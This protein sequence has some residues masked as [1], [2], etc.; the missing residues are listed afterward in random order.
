MRT[1]PGAALFRATAEVLRAALEAGA[2]A[3]GEV[4]RVFEF[5]FQVLPGC[6]AD[7]DLQAACELFGAL[8]RVGHPGALQALLENVAWFEER[9][10]GRSVLVA[11]VIAEMVLRAPPGVVPD[12]VIV[13]MLAVFPFR[14][15]V[16]R[17]RGILE[18]FPA[19]VEAR[20]ELAEHVFAALT[21]FFACP[22]FVVALAGI[23]GEVI[24]CAENLFTAMAIALGVERIEQ[25]LPPG[26]ETEPAIGMRIQAVLDRARERIE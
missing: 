4:G 12:E 26:S 20:A 19:W 5:A 10:G 24:E 8:V 7:A 15:G 23:P 22:T 6:E 18:A 11:E 2:V 1:G 9:I 21:R 13:R 25:F 3:E 17:M 16:R 14:R